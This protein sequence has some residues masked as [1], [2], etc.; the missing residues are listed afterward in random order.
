MSGLTREE[1]KAAMVEHVKE[2]IE[3]E[4]TN[5]LSSQLEKLMDSGALPLDG[6]DGVDLKM[7]R[8]VTAA[9]LEEAADRVINLS[10]RKKH[11]REIKNLR[12]FL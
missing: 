5:K 8:C 10:E 3:M 6:W 9:L 11:Q 12:A 2:F 7:P 4:L 1:A